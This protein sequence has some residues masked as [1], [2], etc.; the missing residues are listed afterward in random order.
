M[1]LQSKVVDK[2]C[3]DFLK[4]VQKEDDDINKLVEIGKSM[5]KGHK[6][7]TELMKECNNE[8]LLLRFYEVNLERRKREKRLG[9]HVNFDDFSGLHIVFNPNGHITVDELRISYK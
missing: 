7:Y 6:E 3:F 8:T 2:Q 1:S 4:I 9:I 5:L